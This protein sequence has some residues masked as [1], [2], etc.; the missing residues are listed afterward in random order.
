VDLEKYPPVAGYYEGVQYDPPEA[1]YYYRVHLRCVQAVRYLLSRPDVDPNR[2]VIVGGSQG[3]RL[4]IVTAALE[5]RVAAVVSA[6]PNSSHLSYLDWARACGAVA[7][8]Y[9]KRTDQPPPATWQDGLDTPLAPLADTPVQ[10][11]FA[12]YDPMNFAP[13][14]RC[15]I[16][17]NCGLIDPISPPTSVWAAYLRLGAT[18]KR[19]VA[20]PGLAHDWSPEFDRQAWRWLDQVLAQ[21]AGGQ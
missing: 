7:N 18:H 15:P 16:L 9:P 17:V 5:P 4:G 2:V 19:I 8:L 13:D 6:I 21:P 10:R 14:V 3:G 11:C 20:L 12:Y 1:Y